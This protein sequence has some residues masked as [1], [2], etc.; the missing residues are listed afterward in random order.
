MSALEV[1]GEA[2]VDGHY[3]WC[4]TQSDQSCTQQVEPVVLD[5]LLVQFS[6]A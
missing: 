3:Y 2:P 1:R 6:T 4:F 5:A